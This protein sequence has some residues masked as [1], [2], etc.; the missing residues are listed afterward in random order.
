MS[1]Y[2]AYM[3]SARRRA[4]GDYPLSSG[5]KPVFRRPKPKCF[6]QKIVV[7]EDFCAAFTENGRP[8]IIGRRDYIAFSRNNN[9][10]LMHAAR[11]SVINVNREIQVR[12]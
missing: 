10:E 5:P 6:I 7:Y 1:G 12:F 11:G 3:L 8:I 2:V 9:I 4:R